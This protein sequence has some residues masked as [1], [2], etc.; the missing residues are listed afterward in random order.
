MIKNYII[1][2]LANIEVLANS[3]GDKVDGKTEKRQVLHHMFPK[4][5]RKICRYN[6]PKKLALVMK[7]VLW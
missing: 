6:K 3:W 2:V 1:L 5:E 7:P 4:I